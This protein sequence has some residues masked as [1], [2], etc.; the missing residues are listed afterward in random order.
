MRLSYVLSTKNKL[1]YLKITLSDLILHRK[2]D[3]EIIVVDA[4]S[5]DG[6][7]EFLQDA[8]KNGKIQKLIS[9]PDYGEA[10]GTNKGLL[11]AQGN[12]IKIMTDDDLFS[13]S[14]IERCVD[15]MEKNSQIDVL[16]SNGG[17]VVLLSKTVSAFLYEKHF[18]AWTTESI[19]FAFCGL[20]IILRRNSLPLLGLFDT[21]FVR[22]DA[23]YSLRIMANKK[24]KICIYT[25]TMYLHVANKNSNTNTLRV[26]YDAETKLLGEIYGWGK[27]VSLIKKI[28]NLIVWKIK[29]REKE[30]S[31]EDF[32]DYTESYSYYQEWIKKEGEKTD[33]KFLYKK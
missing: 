15:F 12:F 14:T 28:I 3:E 26:R 9:E 33:G 4:D 2:N 20:G 30:F 19:P 5:T 24:I 1:P 8:L 11:L 6:T 16:S 7:K 23:E 31:R 25:G 10:H 29:K 32:S 22:L 13:F 18:Q 27:N 21:S 17:K